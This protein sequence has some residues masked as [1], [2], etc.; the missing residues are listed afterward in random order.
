ML[1][2]GK[3]NFERIFDKIS[4]L[5]QKHINKIEQF[6]IFL[7]DLEKLRADKFKEVLRKAYARLHEISYQL[8]YELQQYFENEI[9][10]SI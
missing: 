8:P 2:L 10:V 9:L 6:Y 1:T 3:E 4:Q 5:H 7:R